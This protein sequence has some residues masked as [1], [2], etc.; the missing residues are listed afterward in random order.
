MIGDLISPFKAAVGLDYKAFEARL[1]AAIHRRF[2]VPDPLPDAVVTAIKAADRT[3]AYYEATVPPVSRL[4]RRV[5]IS[6]SRAARGT[7]RAPQRH[8]AVVGRYGDG[9]VSRAFDGSL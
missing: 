2:D 1:L 7:R 5:S 8:R 4:T 3:A 6:A 9:C